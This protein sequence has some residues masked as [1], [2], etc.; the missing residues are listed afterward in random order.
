MEWPPSTRFLPLLN[1]HS[2]PTFTLANI[3][4]Y[5]IS[6]IIDGKSA[7]DFKN[8][9]TKA[10]PLF[11]DGH[12]QNIV[13]YTTDDKTYY[14]ADCLPEMKKNTIYK[15]Q[16]ILSSHKSDVLQAQCGCPAG[17]GPSGSCKHIAALCY[18]LEEFSR[19]HQVRDNLPCTSQLQT[20]NKP[21]KRTLEVAEVN[22]IKF[23]KLEHGKEKRFS[24]LCPYD[25]PPVKYQ[26]T[27]SEEIKLLK[28]SLESKGKFA[29]LHVLTGS[30]NSTSTPS[31]ISTQTLPPIPRSSVDR[32][33]REFAKIHKPVSLQDI[34]EYGKKLILLLTPTSTEVFL[35]EKATRRQHESKRWHEERHGRLTASTFG[36]IVKCKQFEGHAVRKLYPSKSTLSTSAI[37]WGKNNEARA[38]EKYSST[39]NENQQL[40]VCGLHISRHGFLAASPDGIVENEGGVSIGIVEIKCP[41]TH[42]NSTVAD[43]CLKSPFFCETK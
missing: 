42:R 33:H 2:H 39:L 38:R 36:E 5:F 22:D 24:S 4:D 35:I 16:L 15:I 1:M 21:R 26:G 3:T 12:V 41:Y 27:S 40:R 8:M 17:R 43:A 18:A 29:L 11:K 37:Q 30:S 34:F 7:N 14:Q 31:P 20:W 25:P 28:E 9:N 23:V 13:A 6:R 32:I 10:Y 19:I